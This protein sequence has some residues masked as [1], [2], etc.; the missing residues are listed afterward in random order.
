MKRAIR[1]GR[2]I[3]LTARESALL[4]IA[5]DR[6]VVVEDRQ[7]DPRA[8]SSPRGFRPRGSLRDLMGAR[9]DRLLAERLVGFTHGDPTF[10]ESAGFPREIS[11]NSQLTPACERLREP[12]HGPLGYHVVSTACVRTLS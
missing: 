6:V 2:E 8:A 10:A 12:L 11:L 3:A 1:G 7:L 4:E 9:P 5:I